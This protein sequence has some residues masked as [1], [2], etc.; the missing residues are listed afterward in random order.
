ML[1]WQPRMV[2]I[3]TRE[4]DT[5]KQRG[6]R[7]RT[8]GLPNWIIELPLCRFTLSC[9]AF[10]W[11]GGGSTKEATT[12]IQKPFFET[13]YRLPCCWPHKWRVVSYFCRKVCCLWPSRSLYWSII[14][15]GTHILGII[16]P[17]P[18]EGLWRTTTFSLKMCTSSARSLASKCC[19][20]DLFHY[21]NVNVDRR[22]SVTFS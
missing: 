14:R 16:F 6:R 22:G 10:F 9:A 8:G 4:Y 17:Q 15:S 7:G 2:C 21:F 11:G 3:L 12:G 13:L 18:G 5:G 20:A 19:I 1:I